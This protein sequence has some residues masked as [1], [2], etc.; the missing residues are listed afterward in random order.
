M[1][2][3]ESMKNRQELSGS[4]S[5]A[6]ASKKAKKSL[7]LEDSD[8]RISES[9]HRYYCIVEKEG[10]RPATSRGKFRFLDSD[11]SDVLDLMKANGEN[12]K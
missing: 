2:L 7:E 11:N 8:N 10:P 9:L 6:T 4:D 3:K 12:H 1:A 5:E